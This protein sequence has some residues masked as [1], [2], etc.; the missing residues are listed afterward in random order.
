MLTVVRLGAG[1]ACREAGLSGCVRD[2][3]QATAAASCRLSLWEARAPAGLAVIMVCH[4]FW[5]ALPL[6]G[7]AEEGFMMQHAADHECCDM[8][9]SRSAKAPKRAQCEPPAVMHVRLRA[10]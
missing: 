1:D 4:L 3:A 6:L 5:V 7:F 10:Y 8:R 9:I 2:P